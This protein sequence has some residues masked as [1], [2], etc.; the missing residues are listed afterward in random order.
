[1]D[2]DY[3]VETPEEPLYHLNKEHWNIVFESDILDPSKSHWFHRAFFIPYMYYNNV[4]FG[5][6]RL[7]QS[8]VHS[9]GG[10]QKVI[11]PLNDHSS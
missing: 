8:R 11:T 2:A 10:E 9:L 1:M 5:K 7:L 3:G 6:Y 4:H